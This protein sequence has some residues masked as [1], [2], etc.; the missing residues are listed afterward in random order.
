MPN[1][2]LEQQNLRNTHLPLFNNNSHSNEKIKKLSI[3]IEACQ[4]IIY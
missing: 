2:V 1:F 4:S 3:N